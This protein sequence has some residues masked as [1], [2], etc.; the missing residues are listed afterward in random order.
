MLSPEIC[1][2]SALLLLWLRQ[3]S[4]RWR[5][6]LQPSLRHLLQRV[7]VFLRALVPRK[8]LAKRPRVWGLSLRPVARGV[9]IVA[10]KPPTESGSRWFS[11][12][13]Q[14]PSYYF[15]PHFYRRGPVKARLSVRVSRAQRYN[16]LQRCSSTHAWTQPVACNRERANP[17]ATQATDTKCRARKSSRRSSTSSSKES[18]RWNPK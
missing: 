7:S 2:V 10:L 9:C 4:Q 3:H 13:L 6:R 14:D 15:L 1:T 12:V 8:N 11:S 17:Q 18:L 5:G 16:S